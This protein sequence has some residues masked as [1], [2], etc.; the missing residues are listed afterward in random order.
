MSKKIAILKNS[1]GG[2]D[3]ITERD[4]GNNVRI[5]TGKPER[6]KEFWDCLR[7]EAEHVLAK[8]EMEKRELTQEQK[9]EYVKNGYGR[10]PYCKSDGIE[11]GFIS[12]D[13]NEVW[14][15]VTCLDCDKVW[16][17]LYKLYDVETGE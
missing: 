4:S 16:N 3:L 2:Y 17:D 8:M 1:V 12:V 15:K 14:Q 10:C 6:S 7:R 11:G 9:D 5:L 13:G